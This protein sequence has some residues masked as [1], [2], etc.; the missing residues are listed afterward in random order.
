MTAMSIADGTAP[1]T[2]MADS[3]DSTTPK[4]VTLADVEAARLLLDGVITTTPV[5]LAGALSGWL[6]A[7]ST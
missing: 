4:R 6:A 1:G 7:R 2:V 5:R 3:A